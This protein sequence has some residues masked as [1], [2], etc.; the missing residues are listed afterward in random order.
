MKKIFFILIFS[1]SVFAY[2]T[3]G[4]MV[5]SI[6]KPQQK[7]INPTQ[8]LQSYADFQN[9][10]AAL[11]NAYNIGDKSKAY[12]IGN[13]YMQKQQLLDRVIK[14]NKKEAI[15]WFRKGL[16]AGY[17]LNALQL[18]LLYYLPKKE[19]YNSLDTLQQGIQSKYIGFP[20]QASLAV[21]YGAIVLDHLNKNKKYIE[22]AIDLLYPIVSRKAVSS[23][24]YIFANLLNLD[25]RPNLA[26]KYLNSA[27]NNPKVAPAIWN[28][29]IQ[30]K[31]INAFNKKTG[32]PVQKDKKT[33]C[34]IKKLIP[35]LN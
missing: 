21:A 31:N 35:G 22:K 11:K 24:D 12:I 2:S 19:Y 17:G 3:P 23:L 32:Q 4:N 9:M 27:C 5:N 7:V 14:P 10:L 29:C 34:P 33:N 15:K 20:G 8:N 13:I 26:N 6:V 28:M 30:G 1:I 25:N 16:D 18:T